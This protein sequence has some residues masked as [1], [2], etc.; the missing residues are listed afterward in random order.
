MRSESHRLKG[1]NGTTSKLIQFWLTIRLRVYLVRA[2]K[3]AKRNLSQFIRE[4]IWEKCQRT[5]SEEQLERAERAAIKA[6]R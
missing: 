3:V 4:A 1:N 2:S 6:E 5:L